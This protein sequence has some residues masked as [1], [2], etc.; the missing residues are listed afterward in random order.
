MR[1]VSKIINYIFVFYLPLNSIMHNFKPSVLSIHQSSLFLSK[2]SSDL[3]FF[4]PIHWKP[5]DEVTSCLRAYLKIFL[6]RS[7]VAVVRMILRPEQMEK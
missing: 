3:T 4:S 6:A 5:L 2:N 1:P 7:P